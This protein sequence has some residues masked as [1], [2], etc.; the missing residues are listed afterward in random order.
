MD[1]WDPQGLAGSV[2]QLACI[3]G[4]VAVLV[5]YMCPCKP[6]QSLFCGLQGLLLGMILKE[7]L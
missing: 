6:L 3:K 4:V 2:S 1:G 7:A 5:L